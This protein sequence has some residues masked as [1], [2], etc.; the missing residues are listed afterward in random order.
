MRSRLPA[1]ALALI[2]CAPA[3]AINVG[4][5][6][7]SADQ[8]RSLNAQ[9]TS[10]AA[11]PGIAFGSPVAY[12]ADWGQLFGGLGGQTLP[13]GSVDS[14]DGS[15]LVGFGVGDSSLVGVEVSATIISVKNSFGQ[16]GAFNGKIHRALGNRA[17]IA[18]GVENTAG[19]GA[20]SD[21]DGSIYAAYTQAVDLAPDNMRA[22]MPVV[23]NVGIGNERFV[24]PG[25]DSVGLFASVSVH[26]HRQFSAIADYTGRDLNLAMSIVPIRTWPIVVTGG[27]INMTERLDQQAEFA[28]G[29]GFLHQF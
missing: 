11:A 5:I 9:L 19:W 18:I 4:E 28:G 10:P 16:D 17:A 29:I 15:A 23:F 1:A 14:V 6:G 25:E 22:P 8:I 3:Q 20:A 27:M 21:V 2:A 7:L 26:P 12:G 13:D 24:D